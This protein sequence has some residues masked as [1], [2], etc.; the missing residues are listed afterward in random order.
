MGAGEEGNNRELSC[1]IS[2]GVDLM[3]PKGIGRLCD[4]ASI[5]WESHGFEPEDA[6]SRGTSESIFPLLNACCRVWTRDDLDI[7]LGMR[8]H[9]TPPLI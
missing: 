9:G 1:L 2:V 4:D 5:A 7:R 8:G 3:G 6:R